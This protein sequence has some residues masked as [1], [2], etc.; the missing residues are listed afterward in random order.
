MGLQ[1]GLECAG[2]HPFIVG[3]DAY[4]RDFVSVESSECAHVGRRSDNN[5]VARLEENFTQQVECLL[6]T[7]HN[8]YLLWGHIFGPVSPKLHG[9]PFAERAVTFGRAVLQRFGPALRQNRIGSLAETL[10]PERGSVRGKPPAN[11]ITLDLLVSFKISRIAEGFH[12]VSTVGKTRWPVHHSPPGLCSV[13]VGFS[14][15]FARGYLSHHFLFRRVEN[16]WGS[17]TK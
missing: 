10:K 1:R 6:R 15:S 2:Q 8:L 4:I 7:G 9:D 12:V 11:E 3:W 16:S 13:I 17:L 5:G 14:I